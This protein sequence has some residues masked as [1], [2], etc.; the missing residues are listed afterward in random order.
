MAA[1]SEAF[2]RV[3]EYRLLR[4]PERAAVE[5]QILGSLVKA[6]T[7]SRLEALAQPAPRQ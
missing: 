4:D 5:Q 6:M 7:L 2:S 3:C 1:A